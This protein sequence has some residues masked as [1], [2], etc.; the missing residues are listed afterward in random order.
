MVKQWKPGGKGQFKSNLK[1]L[2][3][4]SHQGEE[5]PNVSHAVIFTMIM[6]RAMENKENAAVKMLLEKWHCGMLGVWSMAFWDNQALVV[7]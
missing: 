1:P 6:V 5:I 7:F 4:C 3:L 2:L